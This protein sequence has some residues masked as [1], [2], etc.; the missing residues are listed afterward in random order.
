L[1]SEKAFGYFVPLLQFNIDYLFRFP[2]RNEE[3]ILDSAEGFLAARQP[4][5]SWVWRRPASPADQEEKGKGLIMTQHLS[6]IPDSDSDSANNQ[7]NLKLQLTIL[8]QT[9]TSE[10][11]N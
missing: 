5:T 11:D 9:V 10:F 4:S 2:V 1:L 7:S 3:S 8:K 6:N